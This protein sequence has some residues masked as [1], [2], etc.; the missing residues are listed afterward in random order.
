MTDKKAN[1]TFRVSPKKRKELNLYAIS[2]DTSVQVMIE[3][4][5]ELVLRKAGAIPEALVQTEE[6][7]ETFPL[8]GPEPHGNVDHVTVTVHQGNQHWHEMLEEVLCSGHLIAIDAL[9][10]N[11]VAFTD[12]VEARKELGGLH[13][14]GSERGDVGPRARDRIAKDAGSDRGV[15][16]AAGTGEADSIGSDRKRSH[17]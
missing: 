6:R 9:Q 14:D 8:T 10:K 3:R 16:K 13:E 2:N 15:G 11:I 7:P 4:G 12:L 5:L 1:I 17:G